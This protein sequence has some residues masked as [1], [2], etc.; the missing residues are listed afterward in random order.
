MYHPRLARRDGAGSGRVLMTSLQWFD[1]L[2]AALSR[3][4]VHLA[5]AVRFWTEGHS[6]AL[7]PRCRAEGRA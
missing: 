7:C 6:Q 4:H 1:H 2:A 3:G 5:A